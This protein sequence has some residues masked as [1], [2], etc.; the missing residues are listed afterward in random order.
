M[1]GR[2]GRG[3]ASGALVATAVL[4][5]AVLL[6]AAAPAA[7]AA[8]RPAYKSYLVGD[9]AGWTRYLQNWW[10]AGKTFHAGDELVFKY[11]SRFHDVV[12]TSK[13]AFKKCVV[14]KGARVLASGYDRVTLR[15]GTNYF[16][17]GK[18]GHCANGMKLA[19]KVY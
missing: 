3:S 11:D 17:C 2:R 6:A 15:R 18:P 16:I 4:L 10:P 19:V 8:R 7:E 9:G 13:G 14:S 5:C 12:I 1:A